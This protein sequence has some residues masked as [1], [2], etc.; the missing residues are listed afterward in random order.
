MK[1]L[2]ARLALLSIVFVTLSCSKKSD[3]M[4]DPI[5]DESN[6]SNCPINGNCTTLFTDNADVRS[7]HPF[8]TTGKFRVFSNIVES[9]PITTYLF[10]TVPKDKTSF[11]YTKNDVLSGVVK[12][13]ESCPACNMVP[14]E[15]VDA[16]AKG[17]RLTANTTEINRAKWIVE[18]Q[19][20]R[21]AIG[22]SSIR[23][24]VHLKQYFYAADVKY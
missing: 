16:Y 21:Q 22:M 15:T 20:I 7:S 13:F 10:V 12:Y 18:V 6:L 4:V 24:T 23:D 2:I 9:G 11:T 14:F 5:I 8:L 19:L 17:L 3:I 1:N